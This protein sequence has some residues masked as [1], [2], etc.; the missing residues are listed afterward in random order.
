MAGEFL[1]NDFFDVCSNILIDCCAHCS[2]HS[3]YSLA[4]WMYVS[5]SPSSQMSTRW[6]VLVIPASS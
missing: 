5:R 4:N 1:L 2:A 6:W 3:F